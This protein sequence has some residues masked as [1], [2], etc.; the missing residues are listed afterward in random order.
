M[1]KFKGK[2]EPVIF[3][4]LLDV[5]LDGWD[6]LYE[7]TNMPYTISA[8]YNCDFTC[9][10][11]GPKRSPVYL[12]GKGFFSY[13]D[14]VKMQN[15]CEQYPYHDIRMVFQKN[16]KLSRNAKMTYG[17]WCD[18]RNIPWILVEDITLDWLLEEYT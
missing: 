15:V 16:N 9:V 17:E 14:R 4:K 6:I 18:K 3:K 5:T 8:I 10:S 2:L 12:E 13:K 11:R 1:S 7:E